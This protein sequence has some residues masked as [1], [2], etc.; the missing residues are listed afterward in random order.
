MIPIYDNHLHL[1]P[2]GLNV[3][4][5]KMYEKA[6]GTGM[7]LV[8]LPYTEFV[9]ITDEDHF[10]KTFEITLS[11]AE[12]VR[13]STGLKVNVA[14][15]PYPIS[16]MWL[17]EHVGL[18]KAEKSM[19]K[20]M[21]AAARLVS[22]G[23]A[24]AI[25]EIGRPHFPIEDEK[26]WEASNRVLL[27]GMELAHEVDCPV[28]IHCESE[29]KTYEDLARIADE[30]HLEREKVVKH[31]SLPMITEEENHGVMPSMPASRTLIKEAIPKG[32]RF[33]LETDYIDD[34]NRPTSIMA[35]TTVPKRI[36]GYL[37]SGE[38]TEENVH[39]ICGDIPDSLYERRA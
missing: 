37:Q 16:L 23:K 14:V 25:G 12:K 17:A 39:R 28:I 11:L 38:F 10:E 7:T 6:G 26:I 3:E 8:T 20:G 9:D 18:E 33:M 22:E 36:S 13:E 21:E 5:A 4:A 30:A 24:N 32:D 15:G 35:V 34:P 2:S 31:S 19:I 27:R 29:I 1:S